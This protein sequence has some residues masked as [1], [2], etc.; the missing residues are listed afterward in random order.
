MCIDALSVLN[1]FACHGII[2]IIA[3]SHRLREMI[4]CSKKWAAARGLVEKSEV[5]GEEE[6]RVPVARE[7]EHKELDRQSASQ[8]VSFDAKDTTDYSHL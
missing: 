8:R 3:A 7:F 1:F 4:E 2:V 6:W 5:H